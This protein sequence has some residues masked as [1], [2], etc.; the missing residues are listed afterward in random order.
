[1]LGWL[2]RNNSAIVGLDGT[3]S[4]PM[5]PLD[6]TSPLVLADD[7]AA[8]I[9]LDPGHGVPDT[10]QQIFGRDWDINGT[11]TPELMNGFIASAINNTGAAW[12]ANIMKCFAP[13]DVPIITTLAMEFAL[14]DNFFAAIPGPTFPNRYVMPCIPILR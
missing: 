4:N 14:I 9:D 2:K 7:M 5:N 3:Q 10:A 13:Q 12:A 8:Y 11:T 6:P 1:M